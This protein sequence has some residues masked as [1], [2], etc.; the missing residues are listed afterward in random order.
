MLSFLCGLF[1]TTSLFAQAA[2]H[3][4]DNEK[5]E[6]KS[7]T[8]DF[9]HTNLGKCIKRK[10]RCHRI[11][12][13][14]TGAPGARGP[15]GLTGATGPTGET[16][17]TGLTGETGP[18]GA[19]GPI[20]LTGAEAGVVYFSMQPSELYNM[21]FAFYETVNNTAPTAFDFTTTMSSNIKYSTFLVPFDGT[22]S[23]LTVRLDFF[24]RDGSNNADF[25]FTI[26]GA[27]SSLGSMSAVV[28]TWNT[29]GLAQSTG[30]IGASGSTHYSG[31]FQNLDDVV[32]V[33]AGTILTV[34]I[35]NTGFTDGN[36][37][38][39]TNLS[40]SFQYKPNQ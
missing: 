15:I 6:I 32:A 12:R 38:V 8:I 29:T 14:T 11:C 22:L 3:P 17:P 28:P 18:T 5:R 7:T 36:L 26:Y 34:V 33:T 13:G 1:L 20:G 30:P 39:E 4:F 37:L 40:A 16:G 19:T 23:N 35:S 9:I 2:E 27:S 10:P 21:N 24:S 25:T 31:V